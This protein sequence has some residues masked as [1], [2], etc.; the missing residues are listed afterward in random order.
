GDLERLARAGDVYPLQPLEYE[1]VL[2]LILESGGESLRC[3]AAHHVGELGLVELRPRLEQL[4]G[5]GT[6]FFLSRV[7]ENALA[8]F[9]QEG[10]RRA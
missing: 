7:V 4:R 9:P 6:S 1:D 5:S 8:A 10:A 2:G 3:V